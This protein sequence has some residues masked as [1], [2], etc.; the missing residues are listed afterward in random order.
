MVLRLTPITENAHF[1]LVAC[2]IA[3]IVA[4]S[5]PIMAPTI[6]PGTSTLHT[7]IKGTSL[8]HSTGIHDVI[9]IFNSNTFFHKCSDS[10]LSAAL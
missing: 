6:S 4:P 10:A 8:M 2:V 5:F 7:G 9:L 1:A 3:L